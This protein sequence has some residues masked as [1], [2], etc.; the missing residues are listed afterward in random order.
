[1]KK[2]FNKIGTLLL[3]AVAVIAVSCSNEEMDDL[4][5][6]KVENKGVIKELE[7]VNLE[8]LSTVS[9]DETRGWSRW[10]TKQRLQVVSA[11]VTGA[12]A[13]GKIGG[14]I[15]GVVGTGLGSPITGGVFGAF[16]GA[17]VGGAYNSWLASP[18]T[19]AAINE[20]DFYS[21][22]QACKIVVNDDFSINEKTIIVN[23][24]TIYRKLDVDS[25]LLIMS[26]LDEK[27]L[28]VGRMHNIMLSVMDGS[29]VLN[30]DEQ[31]TSDIKEAIFN[32]KELMDSCKVIGTDASINNLTASDPL[33]SKV[34]ELF[35]IVME[36]YVSE[37]DDVAFI[38]SKYVEVIDKSEDLTDEQKTSIK[39]GLATA[40][41]SFEYWE[42]EF[43]ESAK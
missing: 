12:W 28:T 40:L 7:N 39:S 8:L 1:M 24:P 21:I 38:I 26:R 2:M 43:D 3:L 37:S 25:S 15:G 30:A 20:D 19:R 36:E 35:N 4:N 9:S 16:I 27:F 10:T 31:K 23:N 14:K 41:Y 32:S 5:V 17:V 34:M 33:L 6:S 18:G 29:V 13:G 42:S 11:D 22:G